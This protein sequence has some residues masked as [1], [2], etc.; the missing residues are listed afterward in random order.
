MPGDV[1]PGRAHKDR[2]ASN[3]RS[4]TGPCPSSSSDP[5]SLPSSA[6]SPIFMTSDRLGTTGA[7]WKARRPE[8]DQAHQGAG[9]AGAPAPFRGGGYLTGYTWFILFSKFF[10]GKQD[11]PGR[12]RRPGGWNEVS[13]AGSQQM[14]GGC[15]QTGVDR[16]AAFLSPR[17]H[18]PSASLQLRGRHCDHQ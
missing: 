18:S 16:R 7:R 11:C 10:P 13:Q 6:G 8:T 2:T 3:A 9:L 1:Y 5:V 14:A 12:A 4:P 15:L 17:P